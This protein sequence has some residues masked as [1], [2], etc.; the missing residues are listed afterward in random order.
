MNEKIKAAMAI[1]FVVIL[2]IGLVNDFAKKEFRDA[3]EY[4]IS[5]LPYAFSG[6]N[7]SKFDEVVFASRVV[8]KQQL[9]DINGSMA[10]LLNMNG[11]YAD[12]GMY[13][14]DDLHIVSAAS[15]T[16]TDYEYEQTVSFSEFL[17]ENNINLLYVNEPTKY[18]DDSLFSNNFGI[19]SYSN[20]NM[21]RF[22]ERIRSAGITA[23]DLRENIKEEGLDISDIFYR[24]DHHWTAESGLWASRIIADGLSKYCG[25]SIDTSIYDKSY[26]TFNEWKECWLG[27]QGQKVSIVYVGLDDFTLIRPDFPTDYTFKLSAGNTDGTFDEFISKK[28][29]DIPK[30]DRITN[31]HYLYRKISCINNNVKEGKI[32]LIGDSYANV[33]EPFISLGV[34]EIDILDPRELTDEFSLRDHILQNEYDTVIIAYAQFMLGA[35]DDLTSA[36][37]RMFTFDK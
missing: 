30:E 24:T 36:N 22:I 2:C 16:S 34:H 9:V 12:M 29:F 17:K 31:W 20:R 11:L 37:Y 3:G 19:E 1:L 28:I 33:T 8:N 6:V 15:Y 10:K 21:D 26:Y 18:I 32:L 14:T 7:D 23:I 25:Y 27:E 4:F 13:I 35:H 5:T